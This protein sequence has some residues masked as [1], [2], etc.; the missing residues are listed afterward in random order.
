MAAGLTSIVHT[1]KELITRLV[2]VGADG[3]Y[4]A[5]LG[6]EAH[7]FEQSLFETYVK[8]LDAAVIDH[9]NDLGAISVLHIC[10]ENANV[11]MYRGINA[12]II[13]WAVH[14][15]DY[16]LADGRNIFPGKTLLGGYDDRSGVIVDGTEEEIAAKAAEIIA[17]AGR[18][19][20]I[21]GADCTLPEDI[22][23]ARVRAVMDAAAKL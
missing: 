3:I 14:E 19:R 4:Y 15:S 18:A 17:E 7:R 8:P 1:L 20:L 11:P 6:G 16:T 12:D 21:L 10:K 9:I 23:I 22:E 13:N 5:A 2:E